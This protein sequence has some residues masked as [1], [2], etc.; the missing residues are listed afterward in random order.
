MYIQYTKYSLDKYFIYVM[1]IW[2]LGGLYLTIQPS[3]AEVFYVRGRIPR[4][5][6][7][8]GVPPEGFERGR[9]ILGRGGYIVVYSP[10]RPNIYNIY[11]TFSVLALR[12]NLKL[13]SKLLVF[14]RAYMRSTRAMTFLAIA[15]C[16]FDRFLTKYRYDSRGVFKKK[17]NIK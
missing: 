2:G 7:G 11:T 12:M 4:E 15:Q 3:K 17:L 14:C 16:S 1:Y 13:S 6:R 8:H 9:K 5:A 10:T